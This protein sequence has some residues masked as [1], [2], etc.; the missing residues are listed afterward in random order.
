MKAQFIFVKSPEAF[1][2]D[3][4][5]QPKDAAVIDESQNTIC[6]DMTR[7]SKSVL[8]DRLFDQVLSLVLH[9]ISHLVKTTEPEAERLQSY[10]F[11]VRAGDFDKNFWNDYQRLTSSIDYLDWDIR[12]IQVDSSPL[13]TEA[14][15]ADVCYKINELQ[16]N[17]MARTMQIERI[18]QKYEGVLLKNEGL[19]L[20]S[21][22]FSKAVLLKLFCLPEDSQQKSLIRSFDF[23]NQTS[24]DLETFFSPGTNNSIGLISLYNQKP[25]GTVKYIEYL[26]KSQ[27][28]D[29][30]RDIADLLTKAKTFVVHE[31]FNQKD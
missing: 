10:S 14:Q 5:G 30:A 20:V 18:M 7:L 21:A 26:N 31:F 16:K 27:F 1:C 11:N 12:D 9:E 24:A 15:R 3:K 2:Y 23:K 25:K 4:E 28:Q 19:Q 22:A 13:D 6:F 29:E 8:A 17:I